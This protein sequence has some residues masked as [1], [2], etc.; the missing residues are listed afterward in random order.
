[1]RTP[2]KPN[3][4]GRLLALLVGPAYLLLLSLVFSSV[5]QTPYWAAL[6]ITLLGASVIMVVLGIF[7]VK[8]FRHRGSAVQFTLSTVLLILIP[9]SI[10]L[11]AFRWLYQ[12]LPVDEKI[13]L[14]GIVC[15]LPS[16]TLRVTIR[17]RPKA[18][19]FNR[20][21][22]GPRVGVSVGPGLVTALG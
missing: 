7:G 8:V 11:A 3:I 4:R 10:Y 6:A 19:S 9:M 20:V 13:H 5:T 18:A 2:T 17:L 22:N 14:A 12:S 1:M 15:E 16:F 21:P